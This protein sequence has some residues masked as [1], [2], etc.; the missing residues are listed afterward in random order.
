MNPLSQPSHIAPDRAPRRRFWLISLATAFTMGVTAAMGVWQLSRAAQ[1]LALQAQIDSRVNLPAWSNAELLAQ[2]D[3]SGGH[4]RTVVLS[5]RWLAQHSVYLDNRP[6]AGRSG[7]ILVTPL[8]LSGSSRALLVQRGW[9]PRDFNDRSKLPEIE[10]PPGE[11][12][13]QGR[14]APPPS[15]LFELGAAVQGAIRQNVAVEAFARET[16]LDLLDASVQQSGGSPPG[17]LTDWPRAALD[18]SKHHGYAFQWFAMCATAALLFLWFQILVPRRKR[19]PH[20][21]AP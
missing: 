10:T 12:R 1:K 6:M 17:V 18:V 13:L 7:F 19:V 8:Q 9:V 21:P 11:I 5:G 20:V 2:A 15:Q 14:L 3:L 16:G 4:Y